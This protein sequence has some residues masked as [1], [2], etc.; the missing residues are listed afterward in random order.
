MIRVA[1]RAIVY[2]C[3]LHCTKGCSDSS[4]ALPLGAFTMC[5]RAIICLH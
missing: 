4:G 2:A 5:A 3:T 1:S